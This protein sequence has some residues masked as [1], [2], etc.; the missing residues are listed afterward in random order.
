MGAV[1]TRTT[2]TGFTALH[3]A[4]VGGHVP[5]ARVLVEAGA[6]LDARDESQQSPEDVAVRFTRAE[7]ADFLRDEAP[8]LAEQAAERRGEDPAARRAASSAVGFVPSAPSSRAED[9]DADDGGSRSGDEGDDED[10]TEV[11][12]L[13][14]VIHTAT[15][16][17]KLGEPHARP[18]ADA[19]VPSRL[20]PSS[21]SSFALSP[22]TGLVLGAV[23]VAV[24]VGAAVGVAVGVR[25]ATTSSSR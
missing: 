1:V 22:N 21:P 25:L 16:R 6:L 14:R 18:D 20:S 3:Y 24:A 9:R 7:L 12:N 23:G 19:P 15:S 4:C 10:E 11:Q 17:P 8:R 2:R 13:E 5:V